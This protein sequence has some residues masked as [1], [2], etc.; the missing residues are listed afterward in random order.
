MVVLAYVIALRKLR[1]GDYKLNDRVTLSPK[2][3]LTDRSKETAIVH[4][5]GVP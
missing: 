3:L 1:Q 4:V 2:N 5:D